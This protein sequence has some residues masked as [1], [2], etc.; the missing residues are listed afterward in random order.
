MNKGIWVRSYLLIPLEWVDKETG[1][2]VRVN[3]VEC[4]GDRARIA[5]KREIDIQ[6]VPLNL[7]GVDL[8][9]ADLS[10]VNLSGADLRTAKLSGAELRGTKLSEADLIG[11]KLIGTYL[12]RTYLSDSDLRGADLCEAKTTGAI[13]LEKDLAAE[14]L[15]QGI[16]LSDQQPNDQND[17]RGP[18]TTSPQS[19]PSPPAAVTATQCDGRQER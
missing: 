2:K 16:V 11:A 3:L 18:S 8:W 15:R 19:P 6:K 10:G 9:G 12:I 1:Q 4:L 17:I 7:Q 13:F 5:E 14:L